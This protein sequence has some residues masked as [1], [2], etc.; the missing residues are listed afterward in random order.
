[1]FDVL[2]S[3]ERVLQRLGLR[4]RAIQTSLVVPPEFN[5]N[6]PSVTSLMT[7][8]ESGRWL[9]EKMRQHLGFRDYADK[10]VL[11]FGCGVRFSQALINTA[12]PIARYVGVDVSRSLIEF[13]QHEVWDDRFSYVFLDAHHPV[14]NP[15][16]TTLSPET[17]LDVPTSAFDVA[18]MFSVITHQHPNDATS[19]FSILRR[20]LEPSGRL[21]FT[22]FLDESIPAFEDRSPERN[23]GRCFYNPEFLVNLV[24]GCGWRLVAR[25]PGEG[26]LIGD[27]FVFRL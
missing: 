16:G 3:Y 27:S 17:T 25:S 2:L 7:A 5:R 12:L 6:S 15:H 23:G 18:C 26:P 4:K 24:E 10:R 13:L 8:E 22:C 21:F 9:L 11:D 1:M 14:Y 20:H 19:I